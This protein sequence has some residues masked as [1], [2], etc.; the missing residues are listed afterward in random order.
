[1]KNKIVKALVLASIV[2]MTATGAAGLTFAD[3]DVVTGDTTSTSTETTTTTKTVDQLA[4]ALTEAQEDA[5]TKEAAFT[6]ANEEYEA[7]KA[8]ADAVGEGYTKAIA[9]KET[10]LDRASKRVQTEETATYETLTPIILDATPNGQ[11]NPGNATAKKCLDALVGT[12]NENYQDGAYNKFVEARTEYEQ[13]VLRFN[14]VVGVN[15]DETKIAADKKNLDL[16]KT[17]YENAKKDLDKALTAVKADSF[18]TKHNNFE[19]LLDNFEREEKE[20]TAYDAALSEIEK[21][22]DERLKIGADE[23]ADRVATAGLAERALKKATKDY[24]TALANVKTA[25]DDYSAATKDLVPVFRVFHPGTME[26]LYTTGAHE[27]D[28]LVEKGWKDEKVAWLT[29]GKD[30][31]DAAPVYRLCYPGTGDHHYTT[32]KNERDTLIKTQGWIDETVA[33]YVPKKGD[34]SVYRVYLSSLKIGAHHFTTGRNEYDTLVQN[35]WRPEGVSFEVS[36][37]DWIDVSG[38]KTEDER[39]AKVAKD[40]DIEEYLG[41]KKV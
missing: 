8:A 36:A 24:N 9:K 13:A 29:V 38:I 17:A 41:I 32:D 14:P 2:S 6:K 40:L 23:E 11:D 37:K 12:D 31:E 5:A 26:H 25:K 19:Y 27:R 18:I 16:K 15:N 7:A 3:D 21:L 35:G 1:M 30:A 28:V 33:F 22:K 34:A 39:I 10:D 20:R 4:E